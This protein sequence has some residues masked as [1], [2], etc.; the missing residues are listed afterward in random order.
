MLYDRLKLN[1]T[2]YYGIEQNLINVQVL[3]YFNGSYVEI[4][5]TVYRNGTTSYIYLEKAG[6][7]R[8]MLYDSCSPANVQTF[9]GNDYFDIVFLNTVPFIVT[10]TD[11][12]SGEQIISERVDN[13]VYNGEV[14]L[15]LYSLNSYY[16][17]GGYPSIS[18]TRN[19]FNYTGFTS[20]N[21]TYH[22][23]S[24]GHYSV[25]FTATSATG[26]AI[27]RITYN[28][29]I[30]NENESRNSFS[31]SQYKGYYI[32]SVLKDGQDITQDLIEIGNFST[33]RIDGITYL[34]DISLNYLDRKT[35][36]GHYQITI[37]T[38]DP[39]YAG[40]S[41]ERFT[42]ELWIN[43]QVPPIS[44][45]LAEGESTTGTITITFNV[46]NFY[47]AMG[48][49][50]I[51]IGSAYYYFTADRIANYGETYTITIEDTGTYFIQVYNMS[52]NLLYSY[53]VIRS[54]PLNTFAI[55]A[56]IFGCVAAVAIIVIT[57]LIRR[58]QRV[59]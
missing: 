55:I 13:A 58:K 4:Y 43:T 50:Y 40:S 8:V 59:K 51:R 14:T 49:C 56:I 33:V 5:P 21:Y 27:R 30:I 48:D 36:P 22:F 35:G 46:Q 28:F 25:T 34:A 20:S 32:E 57:V 16:Q 38:N 44:I 39:A 12:V 6:S 2:T 45:S 54:E 18:V 47:N 19:G 3:K 42:F 24:P 7:Y 37:N 31:Y 41:S 17:G 15:S 1:F 29:T 52:N 9:S 53:K 10:Y 23:S 11:T 26:E